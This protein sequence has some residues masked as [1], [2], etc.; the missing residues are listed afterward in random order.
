MCQFRFSLSV[1]VS[2]SRDLFVFV[3]LCFVGHF[4]K[5]ILDANFCFSCFVFLKTFSSVSLPWLSWY[6]T[7]HF[8][9]SFHFWALLLGL[10]LRRFSTS[11]SL[12]SFSP[13]SCFLWLLSLLGGFF[14]SVLFSLGRLTAPFSLLCATFSVVVFFCCVFCWAVSHTALSLLVLFSPVCWAWIHSLFSFFSLGLFFG[15]P[16]FSDSVLNNLQR[17]FLI[18]WFVFLRLVFRPF[19]L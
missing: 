17:C 2:V 19:S 7:F 14:F 3:F 18:Y 13:L 8:E 16:V 10:V 6:V 5:A 1:S 4:S 9:G 12:M 15:L 11:S